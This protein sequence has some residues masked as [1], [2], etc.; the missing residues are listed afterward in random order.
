MASEADSS[1][2][3]AS[4]AQE[5]TRTRGPTS[6]VWAYSRTALDGEDPAYKYC[7]PC[8][9]ENAIPIF[10]VKG[11]PTNLRAHLKSKHSIFVNVAVGHIQATALQQL[12]ELYTRAESS[13]Q[14]EEIDT[15]IFLRQLDPDVVNEALILLIVVQNLPFRTVK[16]PEFHAFCQVLNPQAKGIVITAHS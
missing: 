16:W 3:I 11:V 2:Y 13:G 12:K 15:Y 8:T 14:T 9:E 4:T 7:I 5:S 6:A 10:K 1:S